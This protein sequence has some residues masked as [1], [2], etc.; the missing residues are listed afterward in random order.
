MTKKNKNK[1]GKAQIAIMDTNKFMSHLQNYNKKIVRI[2]IKSKIKMKMKK[3]HFW[4][5]N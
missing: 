4:T 1:M 5:L 2:V 3:T